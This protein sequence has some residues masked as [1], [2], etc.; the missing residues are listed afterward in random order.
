MKRIKFSWKS[1]RR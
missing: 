1:I